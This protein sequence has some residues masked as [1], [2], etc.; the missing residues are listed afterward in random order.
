MGPKGLP[1]RSG[2]RSNVD[3]IEHPVSV[4]IPDTKR[5]GF[6]SQNGTIIGRKLRSDFV[7]SENGDFLKIEL[8]H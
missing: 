6:G 4:S 5:R 8:F 1:N 2:I 7:G 3:D